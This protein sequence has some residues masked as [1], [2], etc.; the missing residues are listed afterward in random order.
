METWSEKVGKFE[1][2][3]GQYQNGGGPFYNKFNKSLLSEYKNVK[4][5]E[6]CSGPGFIGYDLLSNGIAS[7][8]DFADNNPEVK[9]YIELTNSKNN[10]N[11]DGTITNF[12]LSNSLENIPAFQ[13]D[14]I[15]GNPPHLKTEEQYKI[16]E[17]DGFVDKTWPEKKLEYERRIL[18]DKDFSFHKKFFSEVDKYIRVNGSVVLYENADFITPDELIDMYSKKYDHSIIRSIFKNEDTKADF[19]AL[20]STRYE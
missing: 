3:Y 19:Y 10:I 8:V 11:Y 16:L 9:K 5:L 4:A 7:N 18:L 6:I 1:V 2:Y 13:Y 15:I 14:I 17:D 12:Y 20:K